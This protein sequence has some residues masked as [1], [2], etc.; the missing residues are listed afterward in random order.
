MTTGSKGAKI[1]KTSRA[2]EANDTLMYVVNYADDMGFALVSASR[3]APAL[4]AVTVAGQFDPD[5]PSENPGFNMYMDEI[6]EYLIDCQ[7]PASPAG[8]SIPPGGFP[9]TPMPQ[10]KVERDTTWRANVSNRVKVYWGQE[11]PEGIKCSNGSAGCANTAAAMMMTYF[12]FPT[13]IK[14]TSDSAPVKGMEMSLDL[15]KLR[16]HNA[17]VGEK[18]VLDETGCEFF[19]THYELMHLCRELG[20]RS[21]SIYQ[22]NGQTSTQTIRTLN[23]LQSLGFNVCLKT[24]DSNM[25]S[26][27]ADSN[28]VLLMRGTDLSQSVGHMWVCDAA[29]SYEVH[30]VEYEREPGLYISN[31]SGWYPTGVV[32][33]EYINY[34]F[35]NWGLGYADK[36]GYYLG[37]YYNVTLGKTNYN[38]NTDVQYIKVT[39]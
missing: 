11:Y 25:I 15:D 10:K 28:S 38:F 37:G 19:E 17:M 36:C 4:M 6:T 34:R 30:H 22:K 26:D 1:D 7:S 35:Y 5:V 14:L 32:H 20:H 33:D 18:R 2:V 27:L 3:N 31:E 9:I 23:T 24:T 39:R 21:Q 29:I 12:G 16:R 8:S 13:S